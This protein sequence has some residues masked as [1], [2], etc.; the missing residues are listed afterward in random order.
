MEKVSRR[1]ERAALQCRRCVERKRE[2]PSSSPVSPHSEAGEAETSAASGGAQSSEQLCALCHCG[3]RSLLG[4]GELKLFKA[5]PGFEARTEGRSHGDRSAAASQSGR[6]RGPESAGTDEAG[7]R[8]WDELHHVGL[9]DDIDV[10]S[11]FDESGQCWAHQQCALWS[12]GVCQAED[13]SLLNVDRA[14]HSGSTE[15][16]ELKVGADQLAHSAAKQKRS[17][18]STGP[19]PPQ[20]RP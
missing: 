10:H 13:Q 9:P 7:S 14:I 19:Q 11:L 17:L 2:Q 4:Q 5:T 20:L 8:S 1:T 16:S 6:S 15:V 3:A 18:H 12:E